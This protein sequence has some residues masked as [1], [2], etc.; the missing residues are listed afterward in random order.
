MQAFC[1]SRGVRIAFAL[2]LALSVLLL[3]AQAQAQFTLQRISVDTLTN[4]DSVHKTE[5]EPDMFAWGTTIVTTFHVARRPGSVGW[6]SGDVG[7]STS[8]DGGKTWTYGLLP[9]LTV[10]YGLAWD[11]EEPNKNHQFN[12]Y[13]IVCFSITNAQSKVFP[14]GPPGLFYKGDPGCNIAG[15][16]TTHYDR[17]GPRLGFAWAPEMN[18]G[19]VVWSGGLGMYYDRGE[20]FS[21]LSQPAGSGNGGAVSPGCVLQ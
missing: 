19:K 8:T 16:P 17:F 4:S 9:D 15:G 21:Y 2:T 1:V 18:H 6:G 11:V 10:N 13:G 7:F 3:L 20:L 12:G 14:G 5:V